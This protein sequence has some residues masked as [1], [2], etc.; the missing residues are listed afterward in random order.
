[1][2]HVVTQAMRRFAL[3]CCFAACPGA[4]GEPEAG[5]ISPG[6]ETIHLF[7]GKDLTG[8]YTWLK[9]TGKE[10]PGKVYTVHDG[11]IHVSG[12][13]MGYVAT[14]KAYKKLSPGRRVQVGQRRTARETCETQACYCTA[15]SPTAP[16][17][18]LDDL[19][20][21]PARSGLRGRP[22][23]DPRQGPTR[24]NRPCNDQ[25]RDRVGFR[26]THAM[27]ERR[28]E[29]GLFGQAVLVVEAPSGF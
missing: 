13:G 12:E 15:S 1:M 16:A 10:D 17:R 18:C 11:L 22:D 9:G 26:W 3:I 14:E 6:R 2:Y 7:N 25:F 5:A 8:F 27:E 21:V 29:E 23:C 19:P 28:Q 24:E 4:A 20:G